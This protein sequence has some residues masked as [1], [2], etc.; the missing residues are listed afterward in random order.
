MKNLY[1]N[2]ICNMLDPTNMISY[3]NDCASDL[4]SITCNEVFLLKV[5][6][7]ISILKYTLTRGEMNKIL[8]IILPKKPGRQFFSQWSPP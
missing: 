3:L 6:E 8:M 1:L 4:F 2:E 7:K 5:L